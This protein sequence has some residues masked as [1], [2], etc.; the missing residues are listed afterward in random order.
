MSHPPSWPSN[1]RRSVTGC[2]H[3]GLRPAGSWAS[4]KSS[5]TSVPKT[6]LVSAPRGGGT[7]CTRTFIPVR[8]HTAI[9][10]LGAVSV[11]TAMLLPGAAGAELARSHVPGQLG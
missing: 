3:C 7:I 8:P 1:D 11:A 10:V 6:T 4:A 9:G 5:Q 2:S